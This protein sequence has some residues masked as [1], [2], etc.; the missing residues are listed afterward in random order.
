[1]TK[2]FVC[3][4]SLFSCQ[5]G[6]F[7]NMGNKNKLKKF[8]KIGSLSNSCC[9]KVLKKGKTQYGLFFKKVWLDVNHF[10]NPSKPNANVCNT[11]VIVLMSNDQFLSWLMWYCGIIHNAGWML[12]K[13]WP[14]L[15]CSKS[16]L[17][18]DKNS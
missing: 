18:E 15:F 1:M 17:L 5:T 16:K 10:S 8:W 6:F 13:S 4:E 2:V 11:G 3:K 12:V 7:S 14:R 9:C